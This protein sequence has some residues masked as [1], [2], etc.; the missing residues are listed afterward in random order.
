M[1]NHLSAFNVSVGQQVT[2]GQVIGWTGQTGKVTGCHAHFEV[3]KDGASINPESL[4][5]F[6][7]SN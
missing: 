5:G 4:P 2:Q 1:T 3:W 7:R 6:T